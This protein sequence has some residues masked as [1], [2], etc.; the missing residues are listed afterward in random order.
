[1][2]Q[3][4]KGFSCEIST[5]CYF[6]SRESITNTN[7]STNIRKKFEIVPGHA[8]WDQNKLFD[9]KTRGEKTR[10]TVLLN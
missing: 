1:M 7:N 4:L 3:S 10:D 5:V 6:N 9:E 2:H 8:F